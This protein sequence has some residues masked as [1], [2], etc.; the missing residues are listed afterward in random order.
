MVKK[1]MKYE[2]SS[3]AKTIL[4]MEIVLFSIALFN[5]IV[6]FF[7]NEGTTYKI[8]I[9]SSSILLGIA[10][11]VSLVFTFAVCIVRFY[12]N[13]YTS[14]GYLTLT[15]PVTH[16]KHIWAKLLSAV[17]ATV[18]SFVAILL[19]LAVATAGDVFHEIIKAMAYLIKHYFIITKTNGAFYIIEV[20]ALIILATASEYLLIYT[21]IT[22][23]QR[24][25][26]NRI[27]LA[28]G[29][30]FGIYIVWQIIETIFIIIAATLANTTFINNILNWVGTHIFTSLHIAFCSVTVILFVLCLVCFLI[31]KRVM[32]KKLNLE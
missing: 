19:A 21:C 26:K 23:G 25:Q 9:I 11:L 7:E 22:L 15:L 32:S 3:L 31:T 18:T 13:L 4:P 24:A 28:F 14:Q 10:M 30:Y 16:A 20:L 1:L 5:R 27:L 12:R 29:I 6:Q 17:I 8:F 2:F